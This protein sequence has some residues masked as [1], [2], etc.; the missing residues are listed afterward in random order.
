MNNLVNK[1]I[2]IAVALIE[3]A[4]WIE[5]DIFIPSLPDMVIFFQTSEEKIQLLLSLNFLGLFLAGL[6]SGPLSDS[7]GR[8]KVILTGLF[9]FTTASIIAACCN[10]FEMML[11]CRFVQGLGAAPPMVVAFALIY[12]SYN[13]HQALKITAILNSLVTGVMAGAPVLG[14]YLNNIFSWRANFVIV[15]IISLLTL[16]ISLFVQETH[17]IELR[18]K[19]NPIKIINNYWYL[20][21]NFKFIANVLI[22]SLSYAS[23]MIF[24]TNQSLIFINYLLVSEQIFGFYQGSIMLVYMLSSALSVTILNYHGA[25]K[26][27][28][29]GGGLIVIGSSLLLIIALLKIK[30]PLLLCL[31]MSVFTSGLAISIGI[32][33]IRAIN[34]FPDLKGTSS[35]LF[36]CSRLIIISMMTSLSALFFTGSILPVAIIIFIT[37]IICLILALQLEKRINQ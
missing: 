11:I 26:T 24:I 21:R 8:K 17:P 35:S 36:T 2:L 22:V 4:V 16:L 23:L 12:D 27:K 7:Y 18:I 28:N 33:A 15:A 13:E 25:D 5:T 31:I 30:S 14:G 6:F 19:F 37:M 34:I 10:N 3:I 32:F 9:I 20:I 1:F 29:I